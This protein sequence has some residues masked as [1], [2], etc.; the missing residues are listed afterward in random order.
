[1]KHDNLG[2][3]IFS[4][5]FLVGCFVYGGLS[6]SKAYPALEEEL[7]QIN[8]ADYSKNKENIEKIQ[9]VINENTYKKFNL[10]ESYGSINKLLGKKEI[11]GFEYVIDK[12]GYLASGNFWGNIHTID[13][14]PLA[15][16]VR[17][18]SDDM[19]EKGTNTLVLG[20]PEKVNGENK[21]GYSGIPYNTHKYVMDEYLA[22]IRRYRV[23]YIDFRETLEKT[24]LTYDEKFFKTDHHWTSRAAFESFKE[25]I[26]TLN[27]KFNMNL[28]ADNYYRNL[29]NYIIENFENMMLGSSGRSAGINYSQIEDFE[30]IYPNDNNEYELFLKDGSKEWSHKGNFKEAL[31]DYDGVDLIIDN[32][33]NIYTNSLYNIYLHGIKSEM[34]IINKT[35]QDAPKV[36]MLRDSFTDPL[37]AFMAP[38][39]SEI[40]MLWTERYKGN[41]DEYIKKGDYDLVIVGFFPDDIKESFF[42]FYED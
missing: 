3:Y 8:I 23:P 41:I 25:L 22:Y 11:N 2:K 37:A 30:L 4:V 34:R 28:D 19:K 18:L 31:L 13:S 42:R 26:N 39:F 21:N 7:K 29:D 6:F 38:L 12:E 5:I 20:F 36:L 15:V 10:I 24:D 17:K 1:M 35:N 16:R 14:E 32:K 40:D 33:E 9:T 27:E